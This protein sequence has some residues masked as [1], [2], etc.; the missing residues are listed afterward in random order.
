MNNSTPLLK[1]EGIRKSYPM[2][3]GQVE[4]LRNVHLMLPPGGMLS[5][6]GES[7][8]GKSTLLHIIGTL[9]RPT[10]GYYYYRDKDVF[11]YSERKL[12]GFRNNKIGFVFQFHHLLP[13]FTALENTMIPLMISGKGTRKENANKAR[14]LLA[15]V[16]LEEREAHK[17]SELS[18]GE[19]QRVAIARA[20]AN[21]PEL[22][23][24]D[25]PTGNLD[26]RTSQT[27]FDLMVKLNKQRGMSTIIVTHNME[28]AKRTD[29]SLRLQDGIILD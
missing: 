15:E 22:L 11:E 7:G 23:L 14:G 2:G 4:V 19:Q 12:A 27:I 17:P 5:V 9:D 6:V 8:A 18:G 16:G 29:C 26:T 3:I 28:L 24:A 10:E 1:M 13:E 25:E 20:L 21:N